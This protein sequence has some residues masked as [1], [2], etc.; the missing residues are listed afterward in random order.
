MK[1]IASGLTRGS[2]FY[3]VQVREFYLRILDSASKEVWKEARHFQVRYL[4]IFALFVMFMLLGAKRVW[5][6]DILSSL[7]PVFR[8][9]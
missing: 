4:A 3:G 9:Y 6:D 1:V 8:C 7:V 2:P 5:Y